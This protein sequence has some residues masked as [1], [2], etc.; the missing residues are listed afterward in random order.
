MLLLLNF[1][2]SHIVQIFSSILVLLFPSLPVVGIYVTVLA[3][4][5][6][7]ELVMRAVPRFLRSAVLV[8]AVVAHT[9][10]IVLSVP[11]PTVIYF[12]SE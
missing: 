6:G 2:L 8:I 7:I 12:L 10:G 1:E 4:S 3:H 9:L 5:I 11:M